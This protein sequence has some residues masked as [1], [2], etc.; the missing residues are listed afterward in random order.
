MSSINARL[1]QIHE[2]MR[3]AA[4]QAHR[5]AD[6]I[7]LLA[8]SK[9]RPASDIQQAFDAGQRLFGENYLQE[10]LPKIEALKSISAEWH[11]IGRIQSN[12][13]RPIAEN[14]DWVHSID[15]VKHAQRLNDQRPDNLLPLNI[16]LQ[17]NVD[18][19]QTKGGFAPSE[20][21]ETI[22]HIK[23]MPR[24]NLRGLMVIPAP[25]DDLEAQRK[26]FRQLRLLRDQ[27]ATEQH[28]LETLSMGMSDDLEAAIMEGA[29]IV[30]IGTAIFG[31]RA[32]VV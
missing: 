21:A 31:P 30:R 26:P 8:V 17:V 29:T 28:P 24:I 12:K 6:D 25:E 20:L 7:S 18:S 22:R 27:H 32:P 5:N 10:A 3:Q 16:C 11:F 2:R 13:T 19:E 9:T 15:N 1:Q 23:D 14:F 4:E